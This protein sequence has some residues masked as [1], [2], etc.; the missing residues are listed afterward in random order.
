VVTRAWLEDIIG[1]HLSLSPFPVPRLQDVIITEFEKD[2]GGTA[3]SERLFRTSRRQFGR[4]VDAW[5][6]NYPDDAQRARFSQVAKIG[7]LDRSLGPRFVL[8]D[9]SGK[10]LWLSECNTGFGGQGPAGSAR[11]L[12]S[13]GFVGCY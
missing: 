4:F 1:E 9:E 5:V 6:F 10:Q 7:S 8:R 13:A 2:L 11:V 12:D 3:G